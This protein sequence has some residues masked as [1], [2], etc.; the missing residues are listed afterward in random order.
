MYWR[1]ISFILSV[2][3][4]AM[5]GLYY[6]LEISP[7]ELVDTSP[8]TL[9]I[10]YKADYV[11]MVAEAYVVESDPLLAVRRLEHLGGDDLSKT[12]QDALEFGWQVGFS[13]ADLQ[14]IENL[15]KDLSNWIPELNSSDN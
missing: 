9:R 1:Y 7:I 12:I 5:I 14:L 4:G 11:L 2:I 6:G 8:S 10:D 3:F 15:G 13:E